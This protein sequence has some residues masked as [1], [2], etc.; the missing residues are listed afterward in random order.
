MQPTCQGVYKSFQ[1]RVCDINCMTQKLL[2]H[3]L[4]HPDAILPVGLW[5]G[6]CYPA[7]FI[8]ELLEQAILN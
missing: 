7:H 4:C 2:G 1:F 3:L 5:F 6:F 8:L